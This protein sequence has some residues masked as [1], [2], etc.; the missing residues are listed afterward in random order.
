MEKK[1]WRTPTAKLAIIKDAKIT[2]WKGTK[3]LTITFENPEDGSLIDAKFKQP[4]NDFTKKNLDKL[5]VAAGAKGKDII[6]RKVG[7]QIEV[8]E[9]NG[10]VFYDPKGFTKPYLLTPED[11]LPSDFGGFG[12]NEEQDG[13]EDIGF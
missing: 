13:T 4:M 6:G 3:S 10:K 12:N 5:Y 8:R 1:Y 7:I 2:E 9:W 11:E